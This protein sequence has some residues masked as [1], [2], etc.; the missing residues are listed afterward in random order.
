MVKDLLELIYVM[1]FYM[2]GVCVVVVAFYVISLFIFLYKMMKKGG[3]MLW[4]GFVFGGMF[5]MI[6]IMIG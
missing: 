1:R 6:F 2:A 5:Y 4:Y 3:V